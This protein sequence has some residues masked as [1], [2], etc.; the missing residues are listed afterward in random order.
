MLDIRLGND[1]NVFEV[2]CL[3]FKRFTEEVFNM[4]F[5]DPMYFMMIGPAALL[6]FLAQR[7]VK[8]TFKK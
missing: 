5:F 3:I 8:S 6:A 4:L 1:Y 7:Y 2:V